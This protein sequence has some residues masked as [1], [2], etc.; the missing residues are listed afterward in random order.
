MFEHPYLSHQVTTFEQEQVVRAA[1]RRRFL[2]EHADQIVARPAGAMRRMLRRIVGG[3]TDAALRSAVPAT[4][5]ARTGNVRAP[6]AS[7]VDD[8]VR[9]GCEPATATAR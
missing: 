1:E 2:Q 6:K 4:P 8:C 7:T 3:R 9:V 5:S